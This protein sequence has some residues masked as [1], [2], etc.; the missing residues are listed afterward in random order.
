MVLR[1][2]HSALLLGH[3]AWFS[4]WHHQP[5]LERAAV[6]S[7]GGSA[8]FGANDGFDLGLW[9]TDG[10][11]G[12]TAKVADLVPAAGANDR[13]LGARTI[14][15]GV[16]VAHLDVSAGNPVAT[17]GLWYS[18]GTAPGTFELATFE[19]SLQR[20]GPLTMP[21]EAGGTAYFIGSTRDSVRSSGGRMEPFWV[22]SS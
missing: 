8:F 22:P 11:P 6:R 7:F 21:V 19:S 3:R 13:V 18:D 15:V 4:Q 9:S 12:G 1:A 10:T 14:G 5:E 16:Y 17:G 2:E 20:A